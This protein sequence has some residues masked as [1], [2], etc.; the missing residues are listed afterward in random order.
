MSRLYVYG[1]AL[2]GLVALILAAWGYH[3]Y[4]GHARYKAGE[5]AAE[6]R[7]LIEVDL[8]NARADKLEQTTKERTDALE[9]AGETK[10]AELDAR[11]RAVAA[12]YE[13][14]RKQ[15][16]S[17]SE[18]CPPPIDAGPGDADADGSGHAG[19]DD[20]DHREALA[21]YGRD[22]ER[23]RVAVEVCKQFGTKLEQFRAEL[24]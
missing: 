20:P 24:R 21:L 17:R 23:L 18:V 13:R 8:A 3:V 14:L 5:K 11:Y 7:M 10:I 6:A 9:K 15:S 2:G 4:Y 1:F 19:P 22:T 12:R 16:A